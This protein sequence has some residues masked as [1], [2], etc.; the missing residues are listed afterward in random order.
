MIVVP[1]AIYPLH[2]LIVSAG[3]EWNKGIKIKTKQ[4]KNHQQQCLEKI[5]NEFRS[6]KNRPPQRAE[7]E[8]GGVEVAPNLFSLCSSNKIQALLSSGRDN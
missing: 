6:C 8:G 2:D 3:D 5:I 4:K 7:S 1:P